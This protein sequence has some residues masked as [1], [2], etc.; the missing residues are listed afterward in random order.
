MIRI[1]KLTLAIGGLSLLAMGTAYGEV[2]PTMEWTNFRG[3][4]TTYNGNPVPVGS[5]IDAYDPDG[6]HC[7]TWTVK[8]EGIYGFMPVYA[9]DPYSVDV[10]EGAGLGD[11]LT[12]YLNGRLALTEGP[13]DPVWTG[14]G[15]TAEVNLSATA[16][17]SMEATAMPGDQDALPGDTVRYY[18]TVRNTGNGLDFYRATAVTAHG[19]I[20]KTSADF[21]Y[22][23]PGET[24]TVYFDVL[25][26]VALF[27]E[28]DDEADFRVFSGIDNSVYIEGN[29]TTH[30]RIPTDVSD[31][32][33]DILPGDFKL[34]QNYPNPFNPST[35]VAF[36]LSVRSDVTLEIFNILGSRVDYLDLGTMAPGH[37]V[38][39]FD[40]SSLASGIYF[41]K[42]NAG[43]NT[44]MKK[45]ALVK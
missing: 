7:G 27:Y 1:I 6:A 8:T 28:V 29:V 15:T 37:H 35:N 34:Y 16:D 22:A 41:Y 13:D 39:E 30:I 32:E 44:A 33:G 17:V 40:G 24:A 18:V 5:V 20:I 19:W 38:I 11:Q 3:S 12:F 25:V 23:A 36:E 14:M 31:D 45:M 4:A 21:V 10:D 43:S 9:D 2:I 26:P 42:L